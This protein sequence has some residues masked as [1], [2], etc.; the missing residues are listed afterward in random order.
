MSLLFT[1]M[2]CKYTNKLSL[3]KTNQDLQIQ[4]W[5]WTYDEDTYFHFLL[6]NSKVEVQ[7]P[8]LALKCCTRV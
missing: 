6:E 2:N 3:V 4:D 5:L 1:F 8:I 7:G